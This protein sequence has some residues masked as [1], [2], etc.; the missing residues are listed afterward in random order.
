[1][2][3][4]QPENAEWALQNGYEYHPGEAED[5]LD[6][7]RGTY[8]DRPFEM[9]DLRT[10]R[11]SGDDG[12]YFYWRTIAVIPLEGLRLPNFDLMPRRETA[13]MNFL[14]LKGLDLNLAPNASPDERA[15]VDAFN[16]NYSIFGGG[17]RKALEA[18]IKSAPHLVPRLADVASILKP[19]VLRFLAT[20]VTGSV[21]VHDG[22]LTMEAPEMRII[23]AG[24]S[25]TILKG[26][27]REDLLTIA[28]DFLDLLANTTYESPLCA[29]TLENTFRPAQFLGTFIGVAVGFFVG[30]IA[31]IILF[32][33]YKGGYMYLLPLP[34]FAGVILGRFIGNRITRKK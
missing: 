5:R 26:G 22:Y 19:S 27:V 7:V 14:G 13:G 25:H 11:S 32:I 15:M 17:A 12:Y 6:H 31:A 28:N 23:R 20:A 34:I 29:L 21:K 9:Y 33:K 4:H 30:L 1:M 3:T 16:K 2:H 10:E 8:R 24:I 18:S